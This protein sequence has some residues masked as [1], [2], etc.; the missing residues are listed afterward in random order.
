MNSKQYLMYGIVI[1]YEESLEWELKFNKNFNETYKK[2]IRDDVFKL[3]YDV[4]YVFDGRDGKFIII[5][6]II[7]FAVNCKKNDS[8]KAVVIKELSDSNKLLISRK[9]SEYFGIIGEFQYYYIN[10]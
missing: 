8:N 5:G 1:P 9:V 7:D 6:I 2:F 4:P 10:N 3:D